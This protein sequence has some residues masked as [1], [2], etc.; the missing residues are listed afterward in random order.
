MENS[1]WKRATVDWEWS[2]RNWAS[3]VRIKPKEGIMMDVFVTQKASDPDPIYNYTNEYYRIEQVKELMENYVS[4]S[5]ADLV[6]LGGDLN[7]GPE[8]APGKPPCELS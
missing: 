1:N 5:K 3:R 8:T 2:S 4:R 6:L 7:A